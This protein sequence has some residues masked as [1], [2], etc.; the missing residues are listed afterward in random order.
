MQ[1]GAL[2]LEGGSLRAMFTAGVLDVLTEGQVAFSYV[3]GVSAGSLCGVNYVSGQAGRSRDINETF[4]DDKRFLGLRNLFRNGGVFNFDF[5][6]GEICN[7]LN[8]LDR[9]TLF[10]SP[11][12]F[13]AVAT[14]CLTGRPAYFEKSDLA[15]DEFMT[16]CRASSSM[17]GLSE[18]VRL[19]DVPYLDGGC[20]CAIAYQ[21]ALDLEYE[22]IVVVL[23]RPYG[24]RKKPYNSTAMDRAFN[25]VY[26]RYPA[27]LNALHNMPRNY[28]RMYA[29]LEELERQGRIF[30]IRPDRPVIV[31][32]LEKDVQKL[33]DLYQ[34]G[35]RV[36]LE[37]LDGMMTYLNT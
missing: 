11:Q 24:Y 14:D 36:M 35:R 28:N 17:P 29:E 21:R 27:F 26:G 19:R 8:P 20:S 4:C 23:T 7:V 13:E 25:R 12:K 16:A 32:R 1:Q 3:N 22:K 30:V 15:P 18:I 37:Q 9:E 6:F 5:L 2:V 34:D 33:E 10:S 31:G